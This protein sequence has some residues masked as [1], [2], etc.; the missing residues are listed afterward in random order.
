[1]RI[2]EHEN[3]ANFDVDETLVLYGRHFAEDL[4]R[5][6][7]YGMARDLMPHFAHI[8]LLKAYKTRGY[9]IRVQS[10]NGVAWAKEV[11]EKLDI[12]Q[13]VDEVCGKPSKTVDDQNLPSNAVTGQSVY[14]TSEE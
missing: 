12:V 13:Y 2:I 4:I 10:N 8:E 5:F 11:V 6:N 1:M 7:Y 14:I 9:Y 3:I